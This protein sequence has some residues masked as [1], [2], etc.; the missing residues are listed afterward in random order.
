MSLVF[1]VIHKRPY[2][3]LNEVSNH[4][5]D[6]TIKLD[7]LPSGKSMRVTLLTL[8]STTPEHRHCAQ[9]RSVTLNQ[10]RS[11]VTG[12]SKICLLWIGISSGQCRCDKEPKSHSSKSPPHKLSPSIGEHSDEH[13]RRE[14]RRT[15]TSKRD[16]GHS[17]RTPL[18]LECWVASAKRH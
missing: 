11:S 18:D 12:Q 17:G 6:P 2:G 4:Q 15:R 13:R 10:L 7:P 9:R 3:C 14:G 16:F 8:C 1:T 5:Q